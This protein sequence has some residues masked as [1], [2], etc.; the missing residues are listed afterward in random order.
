[1]TYGR[2]RQNQYPE[3]VGTLTADMTLVKILLK[4]IISTKNAQCMTLDI[5]DFYLDTPI[6]R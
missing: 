5:K 6:K 3:D 2:R 4:S 1:M